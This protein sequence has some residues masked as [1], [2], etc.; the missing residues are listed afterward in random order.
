MNAGLAGSVWVNA[1][2]KALPP[3]GPVPTFTIS[4]VAD[5]LA[6]VADMLPDA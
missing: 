1:E 4:R 3:G 5:L 2:G 6:A